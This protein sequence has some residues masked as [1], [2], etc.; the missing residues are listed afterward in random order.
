MS[1]TLPLVIILLASAVFMVAVFR[2]FGMPPLL[3]YLIG[4]FLIGP[5]ALGWIPE[6]REAS[7]LAEFG[8]VFLM[9]SVALEFSL[10]KLF[11][12]RRIV[13]GIGLLQVALTLGIVWIA[14]LGLGMDWKVGMV[15]GAV[16]AMSSTA[17]VSRMLAE[18]MQLDSPQGREVVGVLLFQDLAV[19]PFLVLIPALSA[20][21]TELL[22][23]LGEAALKAVVILGII[24]FVGQRVMRSWFHMVARRRSQE[25]F[26]LNVLL[27]TL[28]LAYVTEHAGLSLALG[29]FLAGILIAETEYRHQV[30]ADIKPFREVL[31]GLFFVTVGMQ[32]DPRMV[33]A[34]L[35]MV[36][37]VLVTSVLLKF[38]VIALLSKSLGGTTGTALRS[39]LALC[40]AGEFGLVLM[41]L[42]VSNGVIEGELAQIV[43]AAMLLSMMLSPVAIHFSDRLVLRWSSSEWMLRSLQ[44]HQIVVKGLGISDHA[45]I[46]GYGRTGQRIAHL[47]EQAGIK[48]MSLDLDPE[49]V[50]E[51]AAAGE[52]VVYGDSSRGEA[53]MGA[54]I[55]RARVM[56]VTF[57]DTQSAERILA[58]ARELNPSLPVVVRTMD[59]ADLDRLMAAGAAEVVPETFES[60]LMLASHAL[61]LL[62]VPLRQVVRQIGAVR[63]DRYQMLRGFFEGESDRKEIE[64]AANEPRLHPVTLESNDHA[65][66]RVLAALDLEARG[67]SVVAIRRYD[68]R[69]AK[70]A[71]DMILET[72]DV[73]VLLG[74]P[75]NLAAVEMRLTRGA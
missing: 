30:E 37:F 27:I 48:T 16:T 11:H 19:V 69:I 39:A 59:D 41:V 34:N 60:S 63:R 73:M 25:L 22:Y 26:I 71:A 68:T 64:D 50:R 33:W 32:L 12:M 61:V 54:G 57:A 51:A 29:A 24:L 38:T 20:G 5:H 56:V 67:V 3:G 10:N 43:T 49:R 9:F 62:G 47:M 40:Q 35:A 4:G 14:C 70:P 28:G 8:V 52:S 31:L 17:I 72:G 42:A 23:K 13:F 1:N 2:T 65:V 53:L 21:E 75:K 18:R 58:L 66:G 45:I 74:T 36:L 46:C 55:A 6:S 7:Y 44:L 15:L